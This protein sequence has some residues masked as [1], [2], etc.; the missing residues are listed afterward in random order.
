MVCPKLS[1]YPKLSVYFTYRY[2]TFC[3][4]MEK[5]HYEIVI[6]KKITMNSKELHELLQYEYNLY[7]SSRL[8]YIRSFLLLEKRWYIWQLLKTL[9]KLE[10]LNKSS[11]KGFKYAFYS[12]K[13]N[14]L[15]YK[16][17]IDIWHSCFD[18]GLLIYHS[19]GIVVNSLAKIGKNCHLHGNNCIGNDGIHDGCPIIGDN[20]DI[21]VGAIII[22]NVRLGNNVRIAANAVV[23]K[24]F[25]EDNVLLAGIPAKIVKHY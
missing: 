13:V 14:K 1:A 2:R 15:S 17:G 24:S 22:G 9:R 6:T 12:R 3:Y 16:L 20:C 5:Q 18:K 19:H 23:N 8:D 10:Y 21:G 4:S 25:Q 7:F 11:N